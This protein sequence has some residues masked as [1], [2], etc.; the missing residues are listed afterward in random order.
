MCDRIDELTPEDVL[1]VAKSTF[2]QENAKQ[3]TVVVMGREDVGDWRGVLRK[4][5]IGGSK[6]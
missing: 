3:A 5:G 2:S 6:A 4:Y 1:R